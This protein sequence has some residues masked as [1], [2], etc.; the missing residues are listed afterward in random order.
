MIRIHLVN[1]DP[2]ARH[3]P[4]MIVAPLLDGR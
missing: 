2:A 1:A 4:D 3:W